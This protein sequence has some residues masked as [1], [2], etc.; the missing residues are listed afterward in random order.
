[1]HTYKQKS[2]ILPFIVFVN[3]TLKDTMSQQAFCF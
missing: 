3:Y 1:M 2:M